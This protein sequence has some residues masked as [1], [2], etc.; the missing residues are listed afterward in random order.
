M[1]W[2]DLV[3][4]AVIALSALLA[5]VR[6]LVREVLGI[7]AWAGAI[8]AGVWALPRVRPRFQEWLGH[9][10]WVDPAAFAVVFVVS[11]IVLLLVT[12]WIS[13]LVRASPIGGVDRTL[14]LVFGLVRGAA[15]VILSYIGAGVVVE[16][17]RWPAPVLNAESI[18]PVYRGARWVVEQLPADYRPRL[19]APPPGR[20]TTAS[21]LLQA[22]PQGRAVGR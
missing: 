14:G 17:N 16:V 5:F 19:Y 7:A 9:S 8:F 15:L 6:G 13:A 4:L 2:V 22:T 1:T 3:V 12:R 18:G 11:L 20:E 10:P 21:A